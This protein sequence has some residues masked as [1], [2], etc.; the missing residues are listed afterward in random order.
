MSLINEDRIKKFISVVSCGTGKIVCGFL[1][2]T[3][4]IWIPAY[5]YGLTNWTPLPSIFTGI[6]TVTLGALIVVKGS[7][8]LQWKRKRGYEED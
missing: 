4:G 2:I 5:L 6:F 7:L 1:V 8:E 3:I